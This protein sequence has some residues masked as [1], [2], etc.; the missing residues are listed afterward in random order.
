MSGDRVADGLQAQLAGYRELVGPRLL[1]SLKGLEPASYLRDLISEAIGAGGKGFRPALC[2]ATANSLGAESGAAVPYAA[3][4]EMLHNAFLVHDDIEDGSESR[5]GLPTLH[6]KHG[7]ALAL[8]AG[9]AMLALSTRIFRDGV[10]HLSPEMASGLLEEFDHLLMQSLEGQAMELGW[11][12]DNNVAFD[13]DDYLRLVLKKTSYY[14]FIHPCRIGALVARG[15]GYDLARFDRFGCL[16]GAAFQIQDDVLNLVGDRAKY[17]KEIAG[18][19]WEGKR[20]LVLS[21][22]LRNVRGADAER[23]GAVLEKPR[24]EKGA[25]DVDWL[26]GQ[27]RQHGSID[28]ARKA[29]RELADAART[30]LDRAFADARQGPDLDFVRRLVAYCVEREV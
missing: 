21:H 7:L 27:L 29:A 1:G 30:E 19:L 11:I 28:F 3:A 9:D 17:G 16:V 14:S 24:A 5:R 8:N 23:L 20:T 4:L 12:R 10:R 26:F 13:D 2:L 6:V 18:D 22:L 15:P 25:A